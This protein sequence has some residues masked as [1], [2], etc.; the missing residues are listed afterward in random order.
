MQKFTCLEKNKKIFSGGIRLEKQD[1][2][3][4]CTT[5]LACAEAKSQPTNATKVKVKVLMM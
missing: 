2:M 5:I 4:E 1:M 3:L